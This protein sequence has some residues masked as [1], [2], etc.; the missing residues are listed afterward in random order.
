MVDL[1]YCLVD[2]NPPIR[3]QESNTKKTQLWR[4]YTSTFKGMP[5]RVSIH[6]AEGLL[7]SPFKVLVTGK[8]T[9]LKQ[10]G[11]S[12][13]GFRCA[14]FVGL[15]SA[16]FGRVTQVSSWPPEHMGVHPTTRHQVNSR[17][18]STALSFG[19]R[20]FHGCFCWQ[21]TWWWSDMIFT[22]TNLSRSSPDFRFHPKMVD[23]YSGKA[24]SAFEIVPRFC[25]WK[26]R[27]CEMLALE[28]YHKNSLGVAP[29]NS[30]K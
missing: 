30:A 28:I 23:K 20:F 9:P 7:G 18:I 13:H 11:P 12:I 4:A 19:W 29:G 10:L 24:R 15:V 27:N 14:F 22:N 17:N 6:H 2:Q 21:K 1:C 16:W 3:C 8:F 5:N 26:S 25:W